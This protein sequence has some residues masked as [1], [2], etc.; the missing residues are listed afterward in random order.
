MSI[1]P[2]NT[3]L[4]FVLLAVAI[5]VADP[6]KADGEF[7]QL[8]VSVESATALA[9]AVRGRL[10]FGA[11]LSAGDD[12]YA[13]GPRTRYAFDLGVGVFLR[14]GPSLSFLHDHGDDDV[15]IGAVVSIDRW[16]ATSFGSLYWLVEANTID[17]AAFGAVQ[18][19]FEHGY[20]L[21][22]SHGGSDRYLDT[23]VALTKRL[24][25]S[26]F[27]LRAGYHLLSEKVFLGITYNSF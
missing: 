14:A 26:D 18:A 27:G 9:S 6:A 1:A 10:D 8:D 24:S 20:G 17:N 23:S 3:V 19:G 7:A 2:I 21:E 25:K 4:R 5:T 11:V 15:E 13:F 22:V 12:G 16:I